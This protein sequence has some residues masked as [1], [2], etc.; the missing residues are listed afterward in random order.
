MCLMIL[1]TEK[2]TGELVSRLEVF[3][4]VY[5]K[6]AMTKNGIKW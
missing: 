3:M 2:W 5:G 4:E 1:G 6:E